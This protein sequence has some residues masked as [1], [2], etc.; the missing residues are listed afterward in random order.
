MARRKS[1]RKTTTRRKTGSRRR[2]R[3]RQPRRHFWRGA[4][5]ALLLGLLGLG[6]YTAYLDYEIR[7]QFEGKRWSLPARVFA[8][9]LELYPGRDLDRAQ[10]VRELEMLHYRRGDAIRSGEYREQG[11]R[12]YLSTRGFPFS[13]GVEAP[14][15]LVVEMR[16]GQVAA[17][18]NL[19]TGG[20]VTLARLEP[21]LIANIYPRHGEDRV[22]VRLDEVPE[23]LV[24]ALIA[25]EDRKFFEHHGLDFS[26]IV[27]A[28][29]ANLRAGRT[30]Q[31]G[32]TITQQLVKNYFL[33]K[34]RTLRRK[35]NEAI[36]ACCWSGATTSR[37]SWRPT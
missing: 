8:R 17:L 27:R 26:A 16:G 1:T 14:K 19:E 37:R 12:L 31:G 23:L 28:A 4:L 20:L 3:T 35:F 22:L 29:L 24:N 6:G 33:T 10:L 18:T 25:V 2:S 13:D 15:R 30:V 36:M 21:V 34:E 9:P 11:G 32:S 5:I 7:S